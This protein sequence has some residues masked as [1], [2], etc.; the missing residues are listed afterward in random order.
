ME[1]RHLSAPQYSRKM[2]EGLIENYWA[3]KMPWSDVVRIMHTAE[4]AFNRLEEA[5]KGDEEAHKEE[6][7]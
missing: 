3:R 7:S 5:V 6:P 4:R 2:V 1:R